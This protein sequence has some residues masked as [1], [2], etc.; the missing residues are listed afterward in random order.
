MSFF[1]KLFGGGSAP[2]EPQGDKVMGEE[3]YKGFT[4]K[5]I[6]MKA[7]G[8]LQL[9]GLIEK[10]IGGELKSYRYIR[11]ERMSSREDLVALALMKGRQI[12]DEQGEQIYR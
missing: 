1:K 2:A 8:E 4:I 6:E 7:G 11:A 10:E 12:I 9:A 3:S 5:A